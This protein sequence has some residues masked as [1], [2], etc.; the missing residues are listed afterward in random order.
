VIYLQCTIAIQRALGVAGLGEAPAA[1]S[2]LGNWTVNN[3]PLG[4]RRAFLFMSDRSLLSF[5]LTEGRRPIE[6]RRMPD[7][8]AHGISLLMDALDAP[9][10]TAARLLRETEEVALTKAANRSLLAVHSAIATDYFHRVDRAGGI[11]HC[12][13][14]EVIMAVNQTPRAKLNWATSSEVTLALLQQAAA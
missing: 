5:P 10:H 14:S 11:Q 3:V 6:L 2:V 8:L 13:L 9:K 1:A 12:D 4:G 7:C